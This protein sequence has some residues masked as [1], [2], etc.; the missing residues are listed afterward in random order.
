MRYVS[1]GKPAM[2]LGQTSSTQRRVK[3]RDLLFNE[4]GT[5]L[6][7]VML[8]SGLIATTAVTYFSVSAQM[9]TTR[10][11]HGH[12][13]GFRMAVEA[14][15]GHVSAGGNCEELLG[16]LPTTQTYHLVSGLDDDGA[17]L[18]SSIQDFGSTLQGYGT[19]ITT[20]ATELH[21]TDGSLTVSIDDQYGNSA[22]M[23]LA[24]SLDSGTG[25][26]S[27]CSPTSSWHG[28]NKEYNETLG[29][30]A[31]NIFELG[32]NLKENYCDNTDSVVCDGGGFFGLDSIAGVSHFSGV[33]H[34]SVL[35]G[36]GIAEIKDEGES[37]SG[38]GNKDGGKG[39]LK[40]SVVSLEDTGMS[41][42]F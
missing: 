1:E 24:H 26:L 9:E 8:M 12:S 4:I 37:R 22:Q 27:S 6:I 15:R 17:S 35:D 32:E 5:G 18:P 2:V 13:N 31:K 14:L 38:P 23:K 34:H 21:A 10:I 36:E 25:M 11:E 39:G 29:V 30:T 28:I 42:T 16:G 41:F 19:Q 40:P 3:T 33:D 7:S 20:F